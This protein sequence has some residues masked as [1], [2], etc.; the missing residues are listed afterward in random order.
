MGGD[1][2]KLLEQYNIEIPNRKELRTMALVNKPELRNIKGGTTLSN[3]TETFLKLKMPI[4]KSMGQHANYACTNLSQDLIL[5]AASDAYCS[6]RIGE[7]LLEQQ[8]NNIPKNNVAMIQNG[9]S[10]LINYCSRSAAKGI[11]IFH[12]IYSD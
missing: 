2:I 7:T 12:G 9:M 3:L 11:L 10:V 5:Y 6:R 1:C 4:E 8:K